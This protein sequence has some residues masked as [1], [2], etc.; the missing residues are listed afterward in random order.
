VARQ[1]VQ[2]QY[3]SNQ[4]RLTPQASPVDTY[5]QPA[6]N[7]QIS[8][9]LDSVAGN[10][11]RKTAS[12]GRKQDQADATAFQVQKI[13][14]VEAAY[15]NGELGSWD[16]IKGD[17]SL[18]DNP[19]Y[20]QALQI[21][22]NQKVGTETGL[23][24]QTELFKWDSEN[25]GL[26]LTDPVAYSEALDAKTHKLLQANLGPD[27]VDAVGFASSIRT[28]VS[29]AT[30]QLK[31]QQFAEYRTKQAALPLENFYTQ[32][33]AGVNVAEIE[34]T[35]TPAQRVAM[36]G[37]SVNNTVQTMVATKTMSNSAI[38]SA[39]T[40]YLITLAQENKDLDILQIAKTIGTGGGFLWGIQ[41][42][43]KK[44]I[45]AQR[46]LASQLDSEEYSAYQKKQR[47]NQQAGK[48]YQ[49]AAFQYYRIH[50]D[51][52]EFEG[53]ES[54]QGMGL[55]DTGV[56][57]KRIA[58]FQESP[59]LTQ[60]D[61]EVFY[62]QFSSVTE[63]TGDRAKEMLERMSIGSMAEW[64]LAESA[65]SD[66]LQKRGSVFTGASYKSG[67]GFINHQFK[68]DPQS[69]IS[70]NSIGSAALVEFDKATAQLKKR[71]T[72]YIVDQKVLDKD[73]KAIGE[74]GLQGTSIHLLDEEVKYELY[75][76]AAKQAYEANAT[77]L[78]NKIG[79][80]NSGNVPTHGAVIPVGTVTVTVKQTGGAQ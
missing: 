13:Q 59:V 14:A 29:A 61:Y 5:V 48:D 58:G 63:L 26:R 79:E 33:A 32:L 47:L 21:I 51:F 12:D 75:Q 8:R 6:R 60:K 7:D 78:S 1:R 50:G 19:K 53:T 77:T 40:E 17:F 54:S 9:A 30:G 66:V 31:S 10:V 69:N 57:Q 11:S 15:A 22:Y 38:N 71:A 67:E 3:A 4:V 70:L 64:R 2:T 28:Q 74:E 25:S 37:Q 43:K 68:V 65:M 35:N 24:I 27:S 36:I 62:N 73:L 18:A 76:H 41:S 56:I 45:A 55:Y 39:T 80:G 16:K 20:G 42:E 72:S 52:E 46:S 49:E 23:D 44:L 34:A